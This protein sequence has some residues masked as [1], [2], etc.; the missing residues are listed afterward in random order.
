MSVE[1]LLKACDEALL[2]GKRAGKHR[3]T[4]AH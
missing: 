2:A 1:D 3:V 4:V